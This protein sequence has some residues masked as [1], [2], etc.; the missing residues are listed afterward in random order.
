[1]IPSLNQAKS[2]QSTQKN[3]HIIEKR[4]NWEA[5]TVRVLTNLAQ[6][7]SIVRDRARKSVEKG[8]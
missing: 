6:E 4:R 2:H 1:M 7:R 3:K 8:I 5:I